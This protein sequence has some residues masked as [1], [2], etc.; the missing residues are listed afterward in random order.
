MISVR[1]G[2]HAL[3]LEL[4]IEELVEQQR[5]AELQGRTEDAQRLG[6]EVSVLQ[7][8]LADT[9]ERAAT[10]ADGAEVLEP[11][12]ALAPDEKF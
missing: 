6:A 1:D 5:R 2:D 11:P 8:E 12:A 4:Q 9:A 7:L 10:R 3:G